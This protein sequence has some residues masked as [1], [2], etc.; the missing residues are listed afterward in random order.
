MLSGQRFLEASALREKE[1]FLCAI[2]GN[3]ETVIH[4]RES[5][6]AA[7]LRKFREDSWGGFWLGNRVRHDSSRPG[8]GD[9]ER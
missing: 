6:G 8:V 7:E 1:K 2:V 5:R 3:S 9:K 4:P